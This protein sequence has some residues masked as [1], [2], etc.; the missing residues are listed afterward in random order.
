M[1]QGAKHAL[2]LVERPDPAYYVMM[3]PSIFAIGRLVVANFGLGLDSLKVRIA[4]PEGFIHFIANNL[5]DQ[6]DPIPAAIK[7]HR[8]G[9]L[10]SVVRLC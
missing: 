10:P 7:Q 2:T 6:R 3:Q 1:S 4:F 5:V 9:F 8:S